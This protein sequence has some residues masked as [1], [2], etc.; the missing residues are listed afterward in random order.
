MGKWTFS[1]RT[2]WD[3]MPTPWIFSARCHFMT[4]TPW[5]FHG[6]P[7]KLHGILMENITCSFPHGYAI[8]YKTGTAVLQDCPLFYTTA[9]C[10]IVVSSVRRPSVCLSHS[11][12]ISTVPSPVK[13]TANFRRFIRHGALNTDNSRFLPISHYMSK[14]TQNVDIHVVIMK[15][16]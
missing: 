6:I 13:I 4:E 14:T 16:F 1:M 15:R 9:I 7:W 11:R 3:S 12:T 8:R 2:R 10:A 5:R